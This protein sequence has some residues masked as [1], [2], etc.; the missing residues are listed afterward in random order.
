MRTFAPFVAIVAALFTS[1]TTYKFT[2]AIPPETTAH[3]SVKVGERWTARFSIDSS[4]APAPESPFGAN[5]AL[6]QG[7]VIEGGIKFSGGY[8]P[9]VDY[10]GYDVLILS[11]Y[12]GFKND[13]IAVGKSMA[14]GKFESILCAAVADGD[15]ELSLKLPKNLTLTPAAKFSEFYLLR[16]SDD[17]EGFFYTT[18]DSLGNDVRFKAKSRF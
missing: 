10:S 8:K 12:D 5:T 16:F 7:A 4:T 14:S 17:V 13:V 15:S 11:D 6:Y 1:C 18:E 9:A 3:P 2:G